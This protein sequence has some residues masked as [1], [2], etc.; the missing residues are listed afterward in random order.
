MRDGRE[1]GGEPYRYGALTHLPR[2]VLY[3]GRVSHH[4]TV[5]PGEHA[6]IVPQKIWDASQAL[7]DRSAPR[8]SIGHVALLA[9]ILEDAH[10]RAMTSA[11]ANKGERR[12]LYYVSKAVADQ[13][14]QPWRLPAGDL[15]KLVAEAVLGLLRDLRRLAGE[16]GDMAAAARLAPACTDWAQ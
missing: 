1:T 5:Y 10:G 7:L 3:T 15:D 13:A 12:Y 8:P 9:G 6:A 4:G 2:N 14:E 16:F 11:H